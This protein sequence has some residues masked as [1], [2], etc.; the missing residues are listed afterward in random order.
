MIFYIYGTDSYL[1]R[2]KTEEIKKG[3]IEKKDKADLNVIRLTAEETDLSRF[4]QE[5]L[6]VPFLSEKKLI[7]ASGLIADN[8]AGQKKI[9]DEIFEFLE[10]HRGTIENNLLFVDV[11]EEEKKIPQKDKLFNLL[12]SQKYSWRLP[13]LKNN[14]L[15]A[16]I[17]RYC[18]KNKLKISAPAVAKLIL[19]VGND[20]LQLEN[21]LAKLKAYRDGEIIA[22][23]DVKALVKAK[24]DNDIFRLTD[25]LAAKN[26][27]L[28]LELVSQQLLAGNEPLSLLGT[29]N[30]QFKA[31]LK[32]KGLLENNPLITAAGISSQAGLHSFVVAKNLPA[33]KK[34]RLDELI[35][36]QNE[37]LEIEIQLKSGAKNPELL[38]DLF[39]ARNS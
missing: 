16:W 35:K 21:E 9:R 15:T 18:D 10:K 1:C 2:A 32:I 4:S 3:F 31:L 25:A 13:A 7:I 39:I 38:F 29:I 30:W 6:T 27:R 22:P 5:V 37:L 12:K 24:Y 23:E 8:R 14:Q 26:R 11:F 17:N 36:I 33:I 28:A 19:A 34:F 20:L